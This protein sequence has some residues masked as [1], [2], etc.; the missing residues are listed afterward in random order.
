MIRRPNPLHSFWIGC[1]IATSVLAQFYGMIMIVGGLIFMAI[2]MLSISM[3]AVGAASYLLG[4][5]I[6]ESLEAEE[7]DND[8]SSN[9]PPWA[10]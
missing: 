6:D 9:D 8:E 7:K 4:K 1:K 10:V 5:S 3:L 2:P